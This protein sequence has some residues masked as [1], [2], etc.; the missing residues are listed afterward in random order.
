MLTPTVNAMPD[1]LYGAV[2]ELSELLNGPIVFR[3]EGRDLAAKPRV[4]S[5]S[6]STLLDLGPVIEFYEP[7][8]KGIYTLRTPR[9]ISFQVKRSPLSDSDEEAD[10]KSV[11]LTI[12][13]IETPVQESDTTPGLYQTSIDFDD[14][15]KYP[16]P[17]TDAQIVVSATNARSPQAATRESKLDI[18][19]DGDGPMIKVES[20]PNGTIVRG[21]Q[22]LTVTVTDVSGLKPGTLVATINKT[23]LVINTWKQ[24][25]SSYSATFD[26]RKFGT[27]LTQLTINVT[28]SD[29]VSNEST[30]AHQLKLDNLPPVIS[31][32]PPLIRESKTG[33]GMTY[34][35]TKFDPLG[36]A[37]SEESHVLVGSRFRAL[38]EDRTNR[39]PNAVAYLA[40]IDTGSVELYLQPDNSVPLLIDTDDDGICDDIN[41]S[42]TMPMD[43]RPTLMQLQSVTPAGSAWYAADINGTPP[44]CSLAADAQPPSLCP[45]FSEMFRVVPGRVQGKPPAVYAKKPSNDG[46]SGECNGESWELL[47]IAH[48]GWQCLAARVH[49]T[50]GNRGVSDAIHICF[51]DNAGSAAVCDPAQKPTCTDG[52]TISDAQR[53]G[54]G[55][56]WSFD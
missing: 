43:Q 34:C 41:I 30:V 31:L 35:S 29:G 51:D 6:L 21:V 36:M 39:A 53:F 20:P 11:A 25:G 9:A 1:D 2:F 15:T 13:G 42:D 32:D 50:I 3:C 17:P 48:E 45:G 22:M 4:A 23:L 7:K 18:V 8:D 19:I 54:S 16:V 40:G 37:A 56:I 27:N 28:A 44:G 33:G 24:N 52:C 55:E 49:D 5:A 38:V 12:G 26:T 46:N 14:R 47:T 10:V